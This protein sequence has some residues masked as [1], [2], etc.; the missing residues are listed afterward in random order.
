M[1]LVYSCPHLRYA[2]IALVAVFSSNTHLDYL[3]YRGFV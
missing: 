1:A 2:K 3:K